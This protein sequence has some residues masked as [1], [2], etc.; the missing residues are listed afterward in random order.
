MQCQVFMLDALYRRNIQPKGE[1]TKVPEPIGWTMKE[2]ASRIASDLKDGWFVNLGIGLPT[3]IAESIPKNK[4]VIFHSEN[5]ILGIGTKPADK[6]ADH[7]LINAGKEPITL[8]DGGSFFSQADSF[9]MIRGGHLDACVL[10]A[11]QVSNNDDLTSWKLPKAKLGGVGGAMDLTV[12]SKR[13]YVFMKHCTKDGKAKIVNQCS[14]PL[15]SKRCVDRIYTE[16][17][18]LDVTKKGLVVK[19]LA[20]GVSFEYVQERTEA[21]LKM[22]T[23]T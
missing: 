9:A 23:S 22:V 5:G 16:L 14:F 1:L 17:A 3:L 15:T 18:I 7:D 10:G 8:L 2:A 19:E 21:P 6:E 11:Y 4:E 20:P 12:G 13:I